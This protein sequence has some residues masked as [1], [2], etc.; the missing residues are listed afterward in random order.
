MKCF[1]TD[2]SCFSKGLLGFNLFAYSL[3]CVSAA[4]GLCVVSPLM[5][6][7]KIKPKLF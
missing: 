3:Q 2:L 1:G 7:T 6:N 5:K 4:G